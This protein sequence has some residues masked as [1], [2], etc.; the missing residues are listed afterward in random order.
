MK[1]VIARFFT[2]VFFLFTC[3]ANAQTTRQ[4]SSNSQAVYRLTMTEYEGDG[5]SAVWSFLSADGWKAHA[6]WRNGEEANLELQSP[7]KGKVLIRRYDV[8]G[9]KEGLIATYEGT[10]GDDGEV[11]GTFTYSYKGQKRSGRWYAILGKAAEG[12]PSVMHWCSQHCGTW[13]LDNGPPY[14]KPHYGSGQASGSIVIVE[15][16]TADS[17]VMRRIDYRPYAGTAILT[18]ALS[19]DGNSIV[20]G[21]IEWTYHPCCGLTKGPYQAAWGTAID[22]VPGSD[23]ERAA[24]GSQSAELTVGNAYD[25]ARTMRDTVLEI[26]KWADFFQLFTSE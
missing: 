7:Q 10:L 21:V 6:K 3:I 23:E 20:N 11:G 18:G 9:A 16:F 26:K 8:E 24:R 5:N 4:P 25:A 17:V 15:K 2:S 12:P 13:R 1:L 22:T 14:D 19:S